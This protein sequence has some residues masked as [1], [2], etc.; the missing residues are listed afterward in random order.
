M[1][2]ITSPS[3]H[4]FRSERDANAQWLIGAVVLVEVQLGS[5]VPAGVVYSSVHG[6][7]VTLT[8]GESVRPP[9]TSEDWTIREVVV[10]ASEEIVKKSGVPGVSVC[11]LPET[12]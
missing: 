10:T 6:L 7:M 3:R 8:R 1:R 4:W 12:W 2:T 11:A 5:D 9:L